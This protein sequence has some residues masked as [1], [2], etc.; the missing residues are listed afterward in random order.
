MT[1]YTIVRVRPGTRLDE[2]NLPVR[3]MIG[4][5]KVGDWGPFEVEIDADKFTAQ[6]LD[7]AVAAQAAHLQQL[8][9]PR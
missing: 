9:G 3:T 6:A 7:A 8:M 4:V 2:R 1:P 5:Y